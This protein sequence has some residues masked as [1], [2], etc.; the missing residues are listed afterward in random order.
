MAVSPV[1]AIIAGNARRLSA[2]FIRNGIT[3]EEKA[4]TI[5]EM[6]DDNSWVV[7]GIKLLRMRALTI[8]LRFLCR[9]RKVVKTEDE[10]YYFA[11][12]K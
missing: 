12:N 11:A 5:Q 8:T 2:S 10:K 6:Y 9:R 7:G 4:V 3:C 1:P